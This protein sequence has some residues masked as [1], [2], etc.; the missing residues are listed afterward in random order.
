MSPTARP[1]Q[2]LAALIA[3]RGPISNRLAKT[4]VEAAQD[5]ALDAALSSATVAQQA[6]FDSDDLQEGAAAFF[7]KR[8]PRFRGR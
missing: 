2:S 3:G 5:D 6:I 7:E 8:G 4:L 1:Y